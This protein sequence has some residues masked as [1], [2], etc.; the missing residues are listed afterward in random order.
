MAK[1]RLDMTIELDGFGPYDTPDDLWLGILKTVRVS[2]NL[3]L[4]DLNDCP[5]IDGAEIL[6]TVVKLHGYELIEK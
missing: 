2:D 6:G 1:I 3:I 5:I 4:A